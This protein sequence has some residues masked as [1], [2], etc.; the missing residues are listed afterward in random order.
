MIRARVPDA[1]CFRVTRY[2]NARC[3]FCLAPNDGNHPPEAV[4]VDRI[5]RLVDQGVRVLH[6][7]GG[8][9][10]IHPA[11][12]ALLD[13]TRGRG[14]QPRLTT[15]GIAVP[16]D[17]VDAIVRTD[18]AVKVSLHGRPEQHD[19]LVGRAAFAPASGTV[20]RLRARGA[21]VSVQ[22]TLVHG[23]LDALDFVA[24]YC[25]EHRV[26]RLS[27]L[28]FVPRGLG[29]DRPAEFGLTAD[30]RRTARTA[31]ARWR[32]TLVGRVDVRWLDFGTR[33]VPVMEA[34]GRFVLEGAR[35]A[36]AR[37]LTAAG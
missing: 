22:T 35:E 30:E 3:G 19:A 21:A 18:T 25:R 13:H 10:T 9:P 32:E 29:R 6:F 8:E 31:V 1:V 5:D 20:R 7:C 26:R 4:L 15:N 27:I 24:R 23:Q 14:A 16:D 36:L 28:P 37:V 17:L 11:L 34:D 12:A 33:P 2:C